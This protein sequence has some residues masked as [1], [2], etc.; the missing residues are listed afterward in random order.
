VN[1]ANLELGELK[2]VF[3]VSLRRIA[4]MEQSLEQI[5]GIILD[6]AV[7]Q[8]M[9]ARELTRLYKMVSERSEDS[10]RTML[11]LMDI[12]VK[13]RELG[14]V[15]GAPKAVPLTAQ[16]ETLTERPVVSQLRNLLRNAID[17]RSQANG[18]KEDSTE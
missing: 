4:R 7:I 11:K 10:K 1:E 14:A 3:V 12:T 15:F 13:G 18:P 9:S 16:A 6:P 8:L 5:E 2:A 17:Q